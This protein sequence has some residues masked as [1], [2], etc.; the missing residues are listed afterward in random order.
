MKAEIRRKKKGQKSHCCLYA[1]YPTLKMEGAGNLV[2]EGLDQTT[3]SGIT[4]S[5]QRG[6]SVDGWKGKRND[7]LRANR[8]I[9]ENG[10]GERW[11]KF[12]GVVS[13]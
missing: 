1:L 2:S 4:G 12:I 3:F 13:A 11:E 8:P 7:I 6:N 10:K 5:K 9:E